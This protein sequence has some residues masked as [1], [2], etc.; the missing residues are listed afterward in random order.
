M[1]GDSDAS[2]RNQRNVWVATQA[3]SWRKSSFNASRAF[4]AEAEA[5]LRIGRRVLQHPSPILRVHSSLVIASASVIASA[6][7]PFCHAF[8]SARRPPNGSDTRQRVAVWAGVGVVE[9]LEMEL[10]YIM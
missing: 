5:V 4:S 10:E 2:W 1:W 3:F 9:V 7:L 8:P 6:V